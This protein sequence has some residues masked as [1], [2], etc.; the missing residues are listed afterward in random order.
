MK[1]ARVLDPSYAFPDDLLPPDHA[2]RRA[3]ESLDT[4]EGRTER[5]PQP[6]DE[7]FAFDGTRTP[8]RPID[9][10][11]LVQLVDPTG[12]VEE[13]AWIAPSASLP[14][15]EARPRTRNRLLVG[16]AALFAASAGLYGWAW[17]THAPFADPSVSDLAVLDAL[18][19]KSQALTAA[20][21]VALALGAGGVALAFT[22]GGG[23]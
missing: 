5:P 8:R 6:R 18:Q 21:G 15:Y 3:Y 10:A 13:T 20:S 1:A 22:V 4:A 16:S 14:P 2:L 19:T 11:T 17:T 23:R 12:K 9:R 7:S